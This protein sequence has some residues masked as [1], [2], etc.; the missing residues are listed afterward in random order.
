MNLFEHIH[1][2]LG[3][4]QSI[5]FSIADRFRVILKG[6]HPDYIHAVFAHVS[7]L[8]FCY[9]Y[10]MSKILQISSLF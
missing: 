4:M 7:Y 1:N 5:I 3:L 9:I 2:R 6:E 10:S 8:V